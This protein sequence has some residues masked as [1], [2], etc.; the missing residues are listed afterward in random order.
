MTESLSSK[1]QR[2]VKGCQGED[3]DLLKAGINYKTISRKPGEKVTAV[4]VRRSR[5]GA[6]FEIS[7][8]GVKMIT[9]EV[10]D[11]NKSTW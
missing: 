7:V 11:Q 4:G 1:V 3:A 6:P 2:A 5:S 8:H 9:R 10:L